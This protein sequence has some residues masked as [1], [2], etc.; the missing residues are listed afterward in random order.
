[1]QIIC[2]SEIF[3]VVNLLLQ[4]KGKQHQADSFGLVAPL[5]L[6]IIFVALLDRD[7]LPSLRTKLSVLRKRLLFDAAISKEE[8]RIE[9]ILE[10]SIVG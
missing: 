5:C 2:C 1:M 3:I 4:Y 9:L 6:F 10:Q 8:R 7:F